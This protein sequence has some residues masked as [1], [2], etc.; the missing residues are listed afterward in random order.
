MLTMMMLE[1][2]SKEC[3]VLIEGSIVVRRQRQE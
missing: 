2:G 1:E 3:R